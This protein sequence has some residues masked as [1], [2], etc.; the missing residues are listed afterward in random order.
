M[1]KRWKEDLE[2][3]VLLDYITFTGVPLRESDYGPVIELKPHVLEYLAAK[4]VI[5]K[6]I[7]LRGKEVRFLRKTIELSLEKF[8]GKLGLTSGTVFHWEKAE[9][10]R[11]TPI[12]EAAVRALMAEE[13]GLQI[14]GHF[15]ELLGDKPQ[16]LRIKATS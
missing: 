7:P 3:M 9:D 2:D 13:L 15:S 1:K 8:A 12:N 14:S 6:R 16:K 4:A 10:E 5:K 11:L